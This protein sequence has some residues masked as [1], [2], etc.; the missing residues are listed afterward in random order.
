MRRLWEPVL[1]PIGNLLW[2]NKIEGY[3]QFRTPRFVHVMPKEPLP[4]VEPVAAATGAIQIPT[5]T[6]VKFT[7]SKPAKACLKKIVDTV[8][9]RLLPR[10]SS[11]TALH[12]EDFGYPRSIALGLTVGRGYRIAHQT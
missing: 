4:D 2:V 3:S 12:T 7:T 9:G 1:T 11:R 10:D 6:V 5:C 8:L